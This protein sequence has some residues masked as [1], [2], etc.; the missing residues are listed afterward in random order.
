MVWFQFKEESLF[1]ATLSGSST[2][3][4]NW[5][6][7]LGGTAILKTIQTTAFYGSG[8]LLWKNAL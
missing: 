4:T 1:T 2:P 5:T 8:F 3:C 7:S 6:L